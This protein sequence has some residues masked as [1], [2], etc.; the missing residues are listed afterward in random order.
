NP[1]APP[2]PLTRRLR[3]A[4][5][6]ASQPRLIT[7]VLVLGLLPACSGE[8][9][10]PL[11]TAEMARAQAEARRDFEKGDLETI[12]RLVM[13]LGARYR[14]YKDGKRPTPPTVDVLALSG[15]GDWGAFG[16]GF[17]VGWG[18]CPDPLDRRPTFDAVTGVS[19][20]AV[21]APFAYL[22]ADE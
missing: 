14:D 1:D 10:P 5:S 20:G 16:S 22:G 18:E 4:M 8:R 7:P 6:S 15:G 21:I 17:L 13:R 19:T 9:R 12:R 2:C 11:G 3:V